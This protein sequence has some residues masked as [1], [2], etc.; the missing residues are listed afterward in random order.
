MPST[1]SPITLR[2]GLVYPQRG[3]GGD[4]GRFK[5]PSSAPASGPASSPA[6][7]RKREGGA[8]VAGSGRKSHCYWAGSERSA[9]YRT[10]WQ[11]Q[12]PRQ[13][14]LGARGWV[15][16]SHEGQRGWCSPPPPRFAKVNWK[17]AAERSLL[18]FLRRRSLGWGW[19]EFLRSDWR[20][21]G[22]PGSFS[23]TSSAFLS[24]PV[25]GVPRRISLF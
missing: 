6:G 10:L 24:T 15:H 5:F 14:G 18:P 2:H 1:T 17:T 21:S 8:A 19:G 9:L 25:P 20:G 22:R 11:A 3:R 23:R 12:E 13:S 4:K 7:L 16:C